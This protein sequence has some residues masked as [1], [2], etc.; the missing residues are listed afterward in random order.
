MGRISARFKADGAETAGRY[1]ISE[2]WL[3]PNTKGPSSAA[4]NTS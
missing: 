1:S 4:E 2:W 3:E